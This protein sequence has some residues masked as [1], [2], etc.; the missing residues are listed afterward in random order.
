MAAWHQAELLARRFKAEVEALYVEEWIPTGE[1]FQPW[2]LTPKLRGEIRARVRS[3][4]GGSARIHV[5]EGSPIVTILRLARTRK[6]HLIVMGTSGRRGMDRIWSGS[7][8]ESVTRLSPVPVLAVRGK[9]KPIRSILAPVNFTDYSDYGF[10][11][12]AGMA[13]ALK[14]PL[15][16]LHVTVDPLHCGNP[17]FLMSNLIDRLPGQVI[18]TCRPTVEVREGVPREKIV[19][20]AAHHGLVVLSAHRKSLFVLGTTAA[21][22]IRDSMVPVLTVPAPKAPLGAGAWTLGV[23]REAGRERA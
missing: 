6:P 2:R 21:R 1:M 10:F 8:T 3:K 13:A 7:V 11:Y 20:E 17:R 12:A 19:A 22:V 5:L 23:K 4:I 14:V 9:A 18:R 15:T 16:A